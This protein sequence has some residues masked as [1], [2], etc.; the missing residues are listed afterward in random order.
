MFMVNI[1]QI[2]MVNNRKSTE[3]ATSKWIFINN[4]YIF[5]ATHRK[6]CVLYEPYSF[7]IE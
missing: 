4:L 6:L 3:K 5:A 1:S 7:Y 2:I